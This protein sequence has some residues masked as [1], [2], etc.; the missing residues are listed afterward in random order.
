V[1][2]TAGLRYRAASNTVYFVQPMNTT[3]LHLFMQPA[4]GA[5]EP[6]PLVSD[7]PPTGGFDVAPD[8]RRLVFSTC[9]ET[10][11]IVKLHRGGA[12][13]EV[14]R[15]G[16]WRD[17]DPV[18]VGADRV[19][20]TS[21]RGGEL[22]VWLHDPAAGEDRPL[23]AP[24][25][26]YPAVSPDR[27]TLVYAAFASTGGSNNLIAR[28]LDQ[29]TE[30]RTLTEGHLDRTPRF[31]ADG[32]AVLFERETATGKRLYRVAL[33]G[34]PASEVVPGVVRA[35]DVSPVADAIA[36]VTR[37]AGRDHLQIASSRGAGVHDAPG[38]DAL[39]LRLR[40]VRF[41]RDGDTL[42]VVDGD[43]SIVELSLATGLTHPVWQLAGSAYTSIGAIDYDLDRETILAAAASADGDLWLAD[44]RF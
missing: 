15:R 12:V 35:F 30:L 2:S 42:A 28:P 21:T 10:A 13:S 5:V 11:S 36:V 3:Q 32:A 14:T 29:D 38:A 23:T 34:G 17:S 43:S 6:T 26:S 40:F 37:S 25:S 1:L 22:Q 19:V 7:S 44:G 31:T 33:A 8:G 9:V 27:K 39:G 16:A 18:A 24:E 20:Y 4:D 41:A